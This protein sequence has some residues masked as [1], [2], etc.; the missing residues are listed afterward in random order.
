MSRNR[1]PSPPTDDLEIPQPDTFRDHRGRGGRHG[2]RS[3]RMLEHGRLRLALLQLIATKPA[4]GYELI[5]AIEEKTRGAYCPSPGVVYPTLTLLEELGYV[6]VAASSGSRKLYSITAAGQ[7]HLDEHRSTLEE[8][9]RR[10]EIQQRRR[11]DIAL[12]IE[13][14]M[15]KLKH[16]LRLHLQRDDMSNEI[17][18]MIAAR[19]DQAAQTIEQLK[20]LNNSRTPAMTSSTA[21]RGVQRVRQEIRRRLLTVKRVTK[22]TPRM[23]CVTLTGD[24]EGFNSPSYD[25]HVKLFFPAPGSIEPIL[26]AGPQGSPEAAAGPAP[27]MRDYTPRRYDAAANELDIEFV[28]HSDGPATSWAA[29]VQPGHT[30]GVG[31]P[32]G[33]HVVTGTFDWYVLVADE[34]GLPAIARRLAELP[35][36]ARVFVIA[37]VEDS[38]EQQRFESPASVTVT[39]IHRQGREPGTP[40]LLLSALHKLAVPAGV[41]YTWIACESNVARALRNY[42]LGERGFDKQWLKAAGYWK[43]G[44]IASHEPLN[45]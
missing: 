37:E 28:L 30:L 38:G 21:T 26:P 2:G 43:L 42:L 24:L 7:T 8:M 40:D 31:G 5:K 1:H 17:A 33:S 25:D 29:N 20:P 10:F 41:G 16:A 32:R 44:A 11:S 23:V 34:A 35:T 22:I 15:D 3:G 9:S 19:L 6:S 4:H 13:L 36:G 18:L 14:S 12:P 45:D 39:W 27:I